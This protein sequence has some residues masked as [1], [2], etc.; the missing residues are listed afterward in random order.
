MT[1]TCN[2][3]TPVMRWAGGVVDVE[4]VI[5]PKP[6]R[7]R[8]L[9]AKNVCQ[10]D[11]SVSVPHMSLPAR[12]KSHLEAGE[13]QGG[14]TE[15]GV[16]WPRTRSHPALASVGRE[17]EKRIVAGIILQ[18]TCSEASGPGTEWEAEGWLYSHP[19][20]V[21]PKAQPLPAPEAQLSLNLECEPLSDPQNPPESLLRP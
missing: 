13:L 4:K 9:Q 20:A 11:C 12:P 10:T 7:P 3:D 5:F 19:G 15:P 6:V 2:F 21:T 17:K 14:C 1:F 16:S 18:R 8:C